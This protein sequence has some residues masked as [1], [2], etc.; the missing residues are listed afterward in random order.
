MTVHIVGENNIMVEFDDELDNLGFESFELFKKRLEAETVAP[1]II[2]N[3]VI[4]QDIYKHI[5]DDETAEDLRPFAELDCSRTELER[6]LPFGLYFTREFVQ[7][8]LPFNFTY[9][10]AYEDIG[11]SP[12]EVVDQIMALLHML[13]NG[14]MYI[15]QTLKNGA[16]CGTELYVRD[17]DQNM[18]YAIGTHGSYSWWWNSHDEAGY[19]F[20]VLRNGYTSEPVSLSEKFFLFRYNPDGSMLRMGRAC[21]SNQNTPLTKQAFTVLEEEVLWQSAG[22]KVGKN[23]WSFLYSSWEFWLLMLFILAAFLS[24][25]EQYVLPAWVRQY[26]AALSGAGVI[27]I[28]WFLVPLLQRKERLR[29][30]HP[31]HPYI[32]VDRFIQAWATRLLVV[33]AYGL[34]LATL[35]MP[36]FN[37]D[38]EQ[39]FIS[40]MQI[41]QRA[42]WVEIV[43]VLFVLAAGLSLVRRRSVAVLSAIVGSV[44]LGLYIYCNSRFTLGSG[45]APEPYNTIV[46]L[47]ILLAPCMSIFHLITTWK[48]TKKG[49]RKEGIGT[50][51]RAEKIYAV[52]Q[53][54]ERIV[55][56][57]GALC[58]FGAAYYIAVHVSA[59]EIKVGGPLVVSFLTAMFGVAALVLVAAHIK[60]RISYNTY[61]GWSLV[62]LFGSIFTP[63]LMFQDQY[64]GSAGDM[65]LIFLGFILALTGVGAGQGALNYR[66][67]VKHLHSSKLV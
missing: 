18:D 30:D 48:T 39:Q 38:S 35:V 20:E 16:T 8:M 21:E 22:K 19:E 9:A 45:D 61:I 67:R 37:P 64:K 27:L 24:P 47:S 44:G 10:R 34:L 31:D 28:Y 29:E 14:Q 56:V 17:P 40:L 52:A 62:I 58:M 46:I 32:I 25:L 42:A 65:G 49:D 57:L 4:K 60:K 15:L 36:L 51:A 2:D 33:V 6:Q 63:L 11:K 53:M 41:S 50:V 5:L 66:N 13:A 3:L 26:P 43:P 7:V 23:V 59:D 1:L 12:E 54:Y 55:W